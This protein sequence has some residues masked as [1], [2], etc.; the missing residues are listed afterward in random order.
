[1]KN[2]PDAPTE[3]QTAQRVLYE[4][5]AALYATS[6]SSAAADTLMAWALS[7][8]FFWRL[9][10]AMVLVWVGLHL[11]QLLRYP[12]L[13]AYHK[14]PQA[15]QRSKFWAQMHSRELLIYSSVWGLAPWLFM[16]ADN[17]P[18]IALMM[19]VMMGISSAG[20]PAVAPRWPSVLSFVVPMMVGLI[21]ALAWREDGEHFFL[22]GCCLLYLGAT[23]H[24]AHQLHQLL[25]RALLMRFEKE[26]L[27]EKLSEQM[28]V[29]QRASEE[30]NRFFAAANHDLR[31]SMHAIALFGAVLERELQGR[32]EQT[33]ATRLMRAV[34][35]LGTSLDT[36]LD[37]S[38]LDAGVIVPMRQAI[39]LNPLFQ[40]INQIFEPRAEE[41]GLQ[42]R[43]RASPLWVDTDP[44]LLQRLLFNLLENAIKYTTEGGVL[45]VARARGDAVWI[46]IQDT[47]IGIA[48]ENLLYIFD[49]FYQVNNPGRDRTKGLGIGLS[50][51]RRL[52]TLLGHP[53]EVHSRL[54]QGTRFRVVIDL[55]SEPEQRPEPEI[56]VLQERRAMPK[57][58]LLIDDESDV[59]EAMIA[60]LGSHGVT[61][62]AVR[63]ERD[64]MTAFA[65]ASALGAPFDALICDYRLADG[66]NG[67][68][69]GQSL[70]ER[71]APDLPMLL[72]TG[73]TAPRRL[74]RVRD[75][76][77]PVLFK[78]VAAE[79]LM[80]T[81]ISMRR[82]T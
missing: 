78:P 20:V 5:V 43:L 7:A 25:D 21:T 44:Q 49:E 37:V 8:F 64:A 75:S 11:L 67:L 15:S 22:A 62:Q 54:G 35:A 79:I 38:R 60:L 18:M 42:L 10:N 81:L 27:A 30:K 50:I 45:L 24:F 52:S 14:D 77:V 12:L 63:D 28:A 40:A 26:A 36:M 48:S 29:A 2:S 68:D 51:V 70:R 76:G 58:V 17:E 61:V 55:A 65:Q 32:L 66:A 74:Q 59:S 72:V 23:L 69:V 33:H 3:P 6:W 71:F 82:G 31:Q 47:G 46:E 16:P 80:K 53:V 56:D 39:P 73:E 57:R 9:H 41:K 4:Q 34:H 13:S 1:V 19:L